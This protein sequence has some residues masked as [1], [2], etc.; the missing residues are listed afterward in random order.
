MTTS[1]KLSN[2]RSVGRVGTSKEFDKLR[3]SQISQPL[4]RNRK[5]TKKK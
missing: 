1:K 2:K 4:P 5:N 3:P